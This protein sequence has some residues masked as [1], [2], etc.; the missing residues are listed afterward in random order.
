ML[1]EER[2]YL[3]VE[4]GGALEVGRVAGAFHALEARAG[5][6][7]VD[8]LRQLGPDEPVLVAGQEE[9]RHAGG[10]VAVDRRGHAAQPPIDWATSATRRMPRWSSRA[11]A[12]VASAAGPGPPG[13]SGDWPNPRWSTVTQRYSSA[14]TGA[15]CH[16]LRWLPLAPCRK[17]S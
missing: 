7:L 6:V 1:L 13:V 3:A 14:K 9:R 12:S 16:Q 2:A 4:D 11:R 10:G 15:C 5:H 8:P 17:S